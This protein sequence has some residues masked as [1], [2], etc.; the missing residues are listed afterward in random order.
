[1]VLGIKIF[2]LTCSRRTISMTG[3]LHIYLV[4]KVENPLL[5]A[6]KCL[7]ATV[8]MHGASWE[9][10]SCL[11]NSSSVYFGVHSINVPENISVVI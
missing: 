10:V 5:D 4:V 8:T 2:A 9:E 1:M 7:E 6:F 3:A 11:I